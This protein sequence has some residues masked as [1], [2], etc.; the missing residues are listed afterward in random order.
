MS[1]PP[2]YDESD[3]EALR[4]EKD[5]RIAEL[6]GEVSVAHGAVDFWMTAHSEQVARIAELEAENA[7]LR[8]AWRVDHNALVLRAS[9]L[10]DQAERA[11]AAHTACINRAEVQDMKLVGALAE[12]ARLDSLLAYALSEWERGE[13]PPDDRADLAARYEAER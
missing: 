9:E 8:E 2:L 10:V 13:I 1:L 3:Y 4:A 12:N 7:R 5:A 6:D 11:E